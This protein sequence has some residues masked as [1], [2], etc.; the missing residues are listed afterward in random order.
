MDHKTIGFVGA[1]N[2]TASL[3]GGLISNQYPAEKIWV[4]NPNPDK[5][6][7]LK[8]CYG[9]HITENNCELAEQ[10]EVL[11]LAV[12][13]QTMFSVAEELSKCAKKINKLIISIVTGIREA[14]LQQWLGIPLPIVRCMP[15]A[16]AVVR[17]GATGM[18]A[19][20]LVTQEQKDL[21]ESLMRGVGVTVWLSDESHIDNVTALSGSG[22]AYFFLV[23][24]VMQKAAIKQGLSTE[25]ANLLVKQT[26][27]GAAHLALES[28]LELA[29]LREKITSAGGTTE[30]AIAVFETAKLEKIFE[31]A[32][33]AAY[34]RAKEL[35]KMEG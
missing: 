27:L 12:K 32:L 3:I 17:S 21:A 1:G 30:R 15:N 11:V 33:Q 19:N 35:A 18:Y 31:E 7:R 23:M 28:D 8:N 22:P 5:L 10:V 2:M 16:P 4:S 26:A 13:P 24:E 34:E 25:I 29:A 14:S 6:E 9:V 20:S